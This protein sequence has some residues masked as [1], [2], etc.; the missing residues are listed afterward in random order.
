MIKSGYPEYEN[1]SYVIKSFL[2][3]NDLRFQGYA[4]ELEKIL[5]KKGYVKV[6]D[7]K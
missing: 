5:A 3:D 7:I 6:D 4:E 1:G 2:S